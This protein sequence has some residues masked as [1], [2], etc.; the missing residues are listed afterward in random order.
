MVQTQYGVHVKCIQSDNGG[1]YARI[2]Q[3]CADLGIK[4]QLSCPY[5]LAQNGRAERKHR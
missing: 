4:T 5:T 2:H 3:L 1:E